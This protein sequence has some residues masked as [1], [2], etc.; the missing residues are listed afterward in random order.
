MVKSQGANTFN[1]FDTKT[2][3]FVMENGVIKTY[4]ATLTG[5]IQE[6]H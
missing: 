4:S 1:M 5:N 6:L 2:G 3:K